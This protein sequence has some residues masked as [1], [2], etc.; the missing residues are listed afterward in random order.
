MCPCKT[1]DCVLT[2]AISEGKAE[3]ISKRDAAF[4][5]D[6]TMRDARKHLPLLRSLGKRKFPDTPL[7]RLVVCIDYNVVPIV[8]DVKRLDGYTTGQTTG[9]MN[10]IARN[11]AL[12]EKVQEN[13]TNYTLLESKISCGVSMQCVLTLATGQFWSS[14]HELLGGGDYAR[15]DESD[16]ECEIHKGEALDE[17]DQMMARLV[18][19]NILEANGEEPTF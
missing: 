19:N 17:V 6:L 13:S 3:S 11:D 15:D 4:F 9:S 12:I 8:F 5:H 18:I 2:F 10:A 7:T 16:E 14:D 1:T